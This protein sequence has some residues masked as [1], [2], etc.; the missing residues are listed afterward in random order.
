VEAWFTSVAGLK[1]LAPAT[2]AD[3]KGLLL[4]AFEDGNP[5]LFLEH[6]FLYRWLKGP[7]PAGHYTLPIGSARLAREGRHA[8]VVS[9]GVGVHWALEAAAA[10][11][12]EGIEIEVVDLRSLQPWDVG[13]VTASVRKTG[14]ALVLHEA[15][16][17]GGFG[18]ELAATIGREAFEWLDAP[19]MRLGALDMPVPFSRSLEAVFSPKGR[20]AP[21]LRELLAY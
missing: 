2:P 6:K 14:R 9:Y 4:S 17:T 16:V 12:R 10:L 3:A 19:V 13:T 18:G 15:P 1:V 7:V 21:A 5:V 11:A 20:L 8:T